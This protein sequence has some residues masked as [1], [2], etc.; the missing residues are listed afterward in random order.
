MVQIGLGSEVPRVHLFGP[1]FGVFAKILTN[2]HLSWG[3][4]VNQMQMIWLNHVQKII[5]IEWSSEVP[6]VHLFGQNFGFFSQ[7]PVNIRTSRRKFVI[8]I[9]SIWFNHV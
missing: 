9:Q 5:L 3:N 2:I 4:F 7:I 8:E 6:P 1:N